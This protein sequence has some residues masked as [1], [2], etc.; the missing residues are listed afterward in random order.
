MLDGL[1]SNL[2]WLPGQLASPLLLSSLLCNVERTPGDAVQMTLVS[3]LKDLN[4]Q[5]ALCKQ[6]VFVISSG[7]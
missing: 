1:G 3:M 4:A 2:A 5:C 6:W 7:G